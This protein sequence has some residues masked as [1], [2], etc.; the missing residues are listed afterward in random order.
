[1]TANVKESYDHIIVRGNPFTRGRSYGQQ[2]KEKIISNINFYK[3]SGVLP[4]WDKVCKY[5]NNHYMNAL[6][7]YYP[8]GLNEMK[9]IAMGSGVDIEDIVLLNSRYEMLRWSRHLHIK[10]KVTDQ[11]QEC[12]GAVC[13]SKATKSGEVLIGQNW[14]INERILNDEIGVLLEVHPDATENIA[15]FFMLTEAGQLGRSGM[16]ANGL[17]IIAMGLLSSEDHFSATTTTGFL[18]I[19]LLIMQF[20]PYY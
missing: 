17:G 4:D 1:M 11:L 12:T 19:T 2:T 15:P 14:D 6:E 3:N 18:P 5:I 20:M 8:S 7:K 13:L 10:S 9:G 16:N